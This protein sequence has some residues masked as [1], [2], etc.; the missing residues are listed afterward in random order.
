M[1]KIFGYFLLVVAMMACSVETS[2]QDNVQ[3][4]GRQRMTRE[5]L[6]EKQARHIADV[7]AMDDAAASRFVKLY[8]EC[9]KEIWALGPKV[10]KKSR[11]KGSANMTDAEVEQDLKGRFGHSQKILDI[12]QKYYKE[13]SKFLSQKQIKRVYEIEKQM[14]ARL[15]R[16]KAQGHRPGQGRKASR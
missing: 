11:G 5:E 8:G 15:A 3:N 1:K 13:Y 10:G 9:Q 4:N 16:H 2:A 14:K 12:R 7:I 6:A